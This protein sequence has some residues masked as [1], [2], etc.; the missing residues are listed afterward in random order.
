MTTE[1]IWVR[2]SERIP[3]THPSTYF[4][5]GVRG[6]GKSSFLESI[7]ERYLAHG[8]A[9]LDLFGSRDGE[10]LAWLRSDHAKDKKIL[11]LRGSQVDVQAPCDTKEAS[12]LELEDFNR[13]DI[14][15]S[16]APLYTGPDDEFDNASKITQLLY[17]RRHWDRLIYLAVREA[18]NL[19][20]SRLKIVANQTIAKAEMV[21]LCREMRHSGIALGL[22][23]LRFTAIDIDI[24]S[25]SDYLI[26]KAQGLQGLSRDLYWLYSLFRPPMVQNLPKDKF[27]IVTKQGSIGIGRFDPVVWHKQEREDIVNRLGLKIEYGEIV[28]MGKNM[29]T[30]RTM[31]DE[32]HSQMIRL[33][34]EEGM[35]MSKISKEMERSSATVK[36][37]LDAHN[38][39]VVR[40]GFCPSCKR[41]KSPFE[42]KAAARTPA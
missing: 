39:A 20:F 13:Y 31:S 27:I 8:S 6:S 38:A 40:S 19:Y 2:G 11:L 17:Q 21:Y 18:S 10:N 12:K 34:I 24:R 14:L 15:I 33:Y 30:F 29:G 5:L 32:E 25:I 42:T 16:S 26:L 36:S 22:D 35:G 9:I 3:Y 7:G 28:E 37:H 41:V 4:C 1:I 23:T